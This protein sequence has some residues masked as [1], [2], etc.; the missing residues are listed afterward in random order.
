MGPAH[1]NSAVDLRLIRTLARMAMQIL[2]QGLDAPSRERLSR[3]SPEPKGTPETSC[4]SS[5]ATPQGDGGEDAGAASPSPTG[6]PLAAGSVDDV[7][8]A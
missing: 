2:D 4:A 6:A 5:R 7:P 3:V 8:P 1:V